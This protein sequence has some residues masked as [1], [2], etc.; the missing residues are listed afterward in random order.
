MT[1]KMKNVPES[2]I[3]IIIIIIWH[4]SVHKEPKT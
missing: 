1:E 3:L 2:I 4:I